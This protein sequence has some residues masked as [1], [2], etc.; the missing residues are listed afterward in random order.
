M[1]TRTYDH[2]I[3]SDGLTFDSEQGPVDLVAVERVEEGHYVRLSR[4]DDVALSSRLTGSHAQAEWI[5]QALGVSK[6][7]ILRRLVRAR[8]RA[9]A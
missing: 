1:S 9:T 8:K 4:A 3:P 6:D 7:T 5:G 2:T